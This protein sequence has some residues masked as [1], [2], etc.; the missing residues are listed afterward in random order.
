MKG[1]PNQKE[2][3]RRTVFNR[4]ESSRYLSMLPG[5]DS[6]SCW[7]A[8]LWIAIW[9]RNNLVE[10]SSSKKEQVSWGKQSRHDLGAP[11]S[12]PLPALPFSTGIDDEHPEEKKTLQKFFLVI[13]S[14]LSVCQI[15]YQVQTKVIVEIWKKKFGK[16]TDIITKFTRVKVIDSLH[17]LS[18]I[19]N[20]FI[21]N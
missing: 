20:L 1:T 7:L 5:N 8:N 10:L 16:I 14:A 18:F 12:P 21:R 11:P 17:L 3:N 9:V 4:H 2:T 15:F 13:V 6:T 19:R